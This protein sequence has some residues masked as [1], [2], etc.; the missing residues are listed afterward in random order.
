MLSDGSIPSGN[1][2]GLAYIMVLVFLNPSMAVAHHLC[3]P[4]T[5]FEC[6]TESDRT[7]I[8]LGHLAWIFEAGC[9]LMAGGGFFQQQNNLY[10]IKV[11]GRDSKI[12]H[13]PNLDLF[14]HLPFT[15]LL[16][17]RQSNIQKSSS[18]PQENLANWCHLVI[19]TWFCLK[20]SYFT[21][22]TITCQSP[23]EW[24]VRKHQSFW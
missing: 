24:K 16:R 17:W 12:Q 13:V 6:G 10:S 5:P 18:K 14:H 7:S 4:S 8:I 3:R 23:R 1:L 11:Q 21:N 9:F 2:G 19:F 15:S 22:F 20:N